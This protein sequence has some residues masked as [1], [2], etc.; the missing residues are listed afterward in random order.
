VSNLP[1]DVGEAEAA[2]DA[3]GGL[4]DDGC[5]FSSA[6]GYKT[7]TAHEISGTA[8]KCP[9]FTRQWHK[10]VEKPR[11]GVSLDVMN[12]K[13][14]SVKLA[15]GYA[16]E[17]VYSDG[18][19]GIVDFSEYVGRGVFRKWLDRKHFELVHIGEDGQLEWDDEIDFCADAL[20]LKVSGRQPEEI[21]PNLATVHA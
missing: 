10:P 12:A 16:V 7:R 11:H 13:L 15:G 14:T 2:T 9:V 18:V 21:F 19:S 3:E 4:D 1:V 17:L 5:E 6:D 20:Y 8:G